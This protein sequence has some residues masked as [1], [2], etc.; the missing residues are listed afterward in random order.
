MK[1]STIIRAFKALNNIYGQK[2]SLSVSHKL[3]T[4]RNL[5]APHWDFQ[6]E[7]EQEV[8]RKYEP[9][10]AD[11]GSVKFKSKDDEKACMDE[12]MQTVNEIAELDVDLGDFK[13][14]VLHLDDKLEMSMEDME[15]LSEFID[16][17]E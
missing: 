2:T 6:T 1:Q 10:I 3:W 13:K 12:Y 16:F 11:D 8:V 17:V 4:L 14:I 9:T 7:K 15:A 5:L